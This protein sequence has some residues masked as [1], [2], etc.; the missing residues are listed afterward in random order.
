[1]RDNGVLP[2]FQRV[3]EGYAYVYRRDSGVLVGTMLTD[4]DAAP[5]AIMQESGNFII[6]S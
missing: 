2:D 4:E 1:M 6:W 3:P 5:L